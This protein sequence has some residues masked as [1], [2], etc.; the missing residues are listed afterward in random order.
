MSGIDYDARTY[1]AKDLRIL[2]TLG[3]A[4]AMQY[5]CPGFFAKKSW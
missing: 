1:S 3:T 2:F 4:T 5:P